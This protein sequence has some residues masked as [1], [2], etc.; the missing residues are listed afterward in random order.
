MNKKKTPTPT[1][2]DN[3]LAEIFQ[4]PEYQEALK[5][6]LIDGTAKASEI[7]LARSLGLAIPIQ[8]EDTLLREAMR[9]MDKHA[10]Q[11][12]HRLIRM[13]DGLDVTPVTPIFN[14]RH[15][16]VGLQFTHENE[17]RPTEDLLGSQQVLEPV[18][19]PVDE[20]DLLPPRP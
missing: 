10:R 4:S 5:Q 17:H 12:L 13:A 16:L 18:E 14:E 15:N 3:L 7:N 20:Q 19:Q 8:D 1:T 2:T 9:R 11:I 6:R